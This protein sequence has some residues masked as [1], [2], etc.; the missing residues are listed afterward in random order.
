M[1]KKKSSKFLEHKFSRRERQIMDAVFRLGKATAVEIVANIPDPPTRDA[2]RRMIRILE[3]KG[4]LNHVVDGPRHVYFPTVEPEKAR[5]SAM[6]HVVQTYFKGSVSQAIA[7]LLE[8]STDSLSEEELR[9]ITGLIK[10]SKKEG[11]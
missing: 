5:L 3:E 11:R 10:K 6:D 9:T 4:F 8:S 7:S 1:S 2:V